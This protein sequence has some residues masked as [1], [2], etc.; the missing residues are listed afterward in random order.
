VEEKLD[1]SRGNADLEVIR[2]LS[3]EI[4]MTTIEYYYILFVAV[5][6][7]LLMMKEKNRR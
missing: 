2:K 7:V 6:V 3:L 4:N 5:L 1:T